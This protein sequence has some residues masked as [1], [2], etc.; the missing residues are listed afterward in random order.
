MK[1]RDMIF[2]SLFTALAIAGAFIRIPL[3]FLS[4]TFQMLFALLAGIIL[5]PVRGMIAMVVYMLIGLVGLPVFSMGGGPG[6]VLQPSFG[7]ILGFIP[8]AF[9]AGLVYDKLKL[10]PYARVLASFTCGA[11]LVY[12]IGITYMFLILKYYLEKPELSLQTT[13]IS[14][15]PYLAKDMVLGILAASMGRYLPQL[16]K[17]MSSN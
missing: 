6:Y 4:I 9:L 12:L 5:G 14:M 7:F 16:K 15:L 2:I 13:L 8:G 3:P 10:K 11:L 17:I 1:L